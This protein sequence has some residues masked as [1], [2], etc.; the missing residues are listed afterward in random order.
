MGKVTRP[1]RIRRM[2]DLAEVYWIHLPEHTDMFAQGY[3]GVTS[4][5]AQERYK[6]HVA[7][8][9]CKTTKKGYLHNVIKKYGKDNLIV[10]T[11]CICEDDYAYD[12]ENKL[13]PTHSIGWNLATGGSNPVKHIPPVSD[14][15]RAIMSKNF[16]KTWTSPEYLEKA[17]ETVNER[18]VAEPVT[19]RFWRR[20]SMS[21]PVNAKLDLLY[22]EYSKDNLA[23]SHELLSRVGEKINPK[24]LQVVTRVV[25][26]FSGGWVPSKDPLWL[27]DYKGIPASGI[28]KFR[29]KWIKSNGKSKDYW[30]KV[31]ELYQLYLDNVHAAE[32]GR[33]SGC[34]VDNAAR[35]YKD[36]FKKGWIPTEDPRWL[37][38]VEDYTRSD[39]AA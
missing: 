4:K 1:H 38:W 29:A 9:L 27:E 18:R 6:V 22:D 3:I 25:R 32:A 21:N 10:E 33:I 16:K 23:F 7:K 13:R 19:E 17:R 30:T 28:Y 12:L 2:L 35:V 26:K 14:E 31:E 37:S 5:T 34:G 24:N 36:Y 11:I 8:A 39:N 20:G 15:V